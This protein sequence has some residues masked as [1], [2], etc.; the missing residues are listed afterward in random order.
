MKPSSFCTMSTYKCCFELVG[1]LLSL[2]IYHPNETIYIIADSKTKD[3]I[4]K[5]TPKPK[6]NIVWFVELDSYSHMDRL[7]MDKKGIFGEFLKNKMKIINYALNDNNDT[8]LLDSDIIITDTIDDIDLTKD[9]GLSPQFINEEY[10]NKTGF[11]N[12][13]MLWCKSNDVSDYWSSIIDNNDSCPEQINMIKLKKFNYFEFGENYNLQCWRYYLST[14][15][16]EQIE[17]Y[18]SIINNKICYKTKPIKFIHTHFHDARFKAFNQLIIQHLINSKNY[19]IL[20]IIYRVIHNKWIIKV[21]KQPISGLGS[22]NNDSFRQ[23][24]ILYKVQH[25][26]VDVQYINNSIHCWIEPNVLLYDRPNLLWMNNEI[27]KSSLLLLG[28]GDIE[29]EGRTIKEKNNKLS[30]Y[31]WIFW[32]RNAMVL[33]K[34]LKKHNIKSYNDRS[35]E[36]IFIG[37]IENSTQQTYRNNAQWKDVIT[38]YYCTTGK[39]H[40]F[41]Q[42]EYLMKLRDSKFGLCLRG[43][44]SKCHREVELMAFGTVPIITSEVCVH[45]F[46]EPLKENIHYIY[47]KDPT[48]LQEKIKQVNQTQWEQMSNNCFDWYQR[49]VH[50]KN[51]WN[52]MIHR[53]LFEL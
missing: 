24:P 28:N 15:G 52:T 3:E 14:E 22:H 16:K 41:K 10:I 46:M 26:D 11:Y 34:I 1:L 40:L 37:N 42:D 31:P 4:E 39:T 6:L 18:I 7:I 44:G 48:D 9:V 30:V 5:I 47:V 36:S 33:E 20:L 50:S 45:S 49:N 21:P 13:G 53:I 12:A 43:Y 2:S 23:L 35:N 51:S 29:V 17:S 8:L 27:F 32:P 25:S 19:K 38:E